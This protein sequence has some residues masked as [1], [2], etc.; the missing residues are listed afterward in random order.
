MGS[1]SME[2]L[3]EFIDSFS[4]EELEILRIYINENNNNEQDVKVRCQVN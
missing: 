1:S 4:E 3:R 2:Q